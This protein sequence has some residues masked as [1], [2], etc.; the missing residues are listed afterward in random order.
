MNLRTY[1]ISGLLSALL[2][3]PFSLHATESDAS[4]EQ[5]ILVKI[6]QYRKAHGLNPLRMNPL[7]SSEA[8]QHSRDMANHK[9]PFGHA[10]FSER[11]KRIY[12]R[13]PQQPMGA[14]ENVAYNYKSASI[15]VNGWLK[16][17]GHKRNID[18]KYNL[19]GIGVVHDKQGRLYFTQ[20]FL[21]VND[22]A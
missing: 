9:I 11:V 21:R 7:M 10:Y 22:K 16:S 2:S 6:N 8:R 12:A 1:L 19:T 3:L 5:E 20:I 4:I 13:V 17:P 15:V 14:A 18:G